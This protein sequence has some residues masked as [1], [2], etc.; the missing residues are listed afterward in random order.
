MISSVIG[1]S[2]RFDSQ[3]HITFAI[4]SNNKKKK[5][6]IDETNEKDRQ[7]AKWCAVDKSKKERKKYYSIWKGNHLT[8]SMESTNANS[9]IITETN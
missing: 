2:I 6:K 5:T 7:C 3:C 4:F 1:H 8:H 9:Y